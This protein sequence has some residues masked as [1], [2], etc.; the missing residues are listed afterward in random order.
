MIDLDNIEDSIERIYETYH[1]DVYRFLI[2]FTGNQ[3]DAEDLTQEVFIKVL[4]SL[5]TFNHRVKLKTWILAIAKH[6]AIDHFRRKRFITFKDSFFNRIESKDKT[7]DKILL[8]S[9]KKMILLEAIGTLK[10]NLRVVVIL[11]GISDYSIHE[12]AE[13]LDCTESK[14]KVDYHRALKKLKERLDLSLEEVIGDAK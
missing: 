5:S 1:L 2:C 11:R 12:T 3:T 9:E 6:T 4:H 14:V 10:P 13:I 8:D 7:P